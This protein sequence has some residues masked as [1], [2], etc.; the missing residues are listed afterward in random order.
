[1][2]PLKF[3]F[4]YSPASPRSSK[5]DCDRIADQT[6]SER[7]LLSSVLFL[8]FFFFFFF[9]SLLSTVLLF[10][11][12]AMETADRFS[13]LAR[14]DLPFVEYTCWSK[15][16][17]LGQFCFNSFIHDSHWAF[18]WL[19]C[20][21]NLTNRSGSPKCHHSTWYVGQMKVSGVG[22]IWAF[23]NFAF[24]AIS[25]DAFLKPRRMNM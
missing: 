13:A 24:Q 17:D 11:A 6:R 10:F 15:V 22:L 8:C 18:L 4:K 19:T 16:L 12:T 5:R 20:G 7:H 23:R 2:T 3:I 21:P 9:Y 25:P 14:R 1:M